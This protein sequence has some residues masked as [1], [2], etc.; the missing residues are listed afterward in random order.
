MTHKPYSLQCCY[1]LH[2]KYQHYDP[3]SK[4]IKADYELSA[5]NCD[6]THL[7]L[8]QTLYNLS[9]YGPMKQDIE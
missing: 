7:A 1:F 6:R 2:Y 4:E 3:V 5:R 8:Y 9:F